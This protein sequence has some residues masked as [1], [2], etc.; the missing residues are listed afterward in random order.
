[1]GPLDKKKVNEEKKDSDTEDME[2]GEQAQ[3]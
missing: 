3:G 1:L 2:E